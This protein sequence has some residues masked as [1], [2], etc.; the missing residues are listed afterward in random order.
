MA[1]MLKR[2]FHTNFNLSNNKDIV[3][4]YLDRIIQ[5]LKG[6]NNDFLFSVI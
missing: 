1:I 4:F 3:G 5:S 2:I 6:F